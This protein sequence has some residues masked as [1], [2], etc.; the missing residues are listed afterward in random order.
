MSLSDTTPEAAALQTAI[1]RRLGA[2]GRFRLAVE[3]SDLVRDLAEA[4]VKDHSVSAT[5]PAARDDPGPH[6]PTEAE[7]TV[8]VRGLFVRIRAA[9]DAAGIPHMLTGSFASSLHGAPRATQDIDIVIAPTRD[10]LL[11]LLSHLPDA[12]YYVSRDAALDA[13]LRHEQF[14]VIEIATGWKVDLII[15]KP[16]EFSREEFERRRPV[17]VSGVTLD[18]ATAEDVL[19]AKLEWAK[20]GAS[21]RQIED[22]AGIIRL[23]GDRLDRGYVERWVDALELNEQWHDARAQSH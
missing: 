5:P 22:A 13:L 9:L 16:R 2:D 7:A 23:Q 14:N 17:Q 8:S 11:E 19:I 21:A 20:R 3:I 1:H 6:A 18:V 12:E 15:R 4:G 10:Q